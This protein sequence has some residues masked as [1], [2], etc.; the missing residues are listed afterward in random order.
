LNKKLL[1]VLI[2]C[3]P[4]P[5]AAAEEAALPSTGTLTCEYLEFLPEKDA[6]AARGEV[7]LKSSGSLLIADEAH[8]YMG[9]RRAEARGR[10][11]PSHGKADYYWE[12]STGTLSSGYVLDPPWRIWGRS[13]RREPERYEIRRAAL[14]NCDLDPPHFHFRGRKGRYRPG[15]RATVYGG[16]LA[17]GED[18]V[19]YTPVYTRSLKKRRWSLRVDPGQNG[20]QGVFARSVFGY[21]ISD[22]TYGRLYWDHYEKTGNGVG[23]EYSYFHPL[24]KGSL[25]S[26]RIE[27]RVAQTER[28]NFKAGHWQQ[29]RPRWS[30]QA[31]A[32]FQSDS[33]FS[34]L[35]FRD[36]FE[37]VRQKAESDLAV[38]YQDPL[39]SARVSV[40][41][42]EI[43]SPA[44]NKFVRQK[45]TLPHLSLQSSA[46]KL[47][48]SDLYASLGGNFRNEYVRPQA[49]PSAADPIVPERDLYRQTADV[50]G[51]L[52]KMVK[53]T[54]KIT[55][56]PSVG[57]S[58]S[59]QAWREAP[60]G[61]IDRDDLYQGRIFTRTNMRHRLLRS[62]DYDVNYVYRVRWSPNQFKRDHAAA[63]EGLE[64]HGA[65]LF[66]SYRPARRFWARLSSGYD[67]RDPEGQTVRSVRQKI[68]P[69]TAE[70]N[71][72]PRKDVSL[73]YRHGVALFPVRRTSLSQFSVQLGPATRTHF[74]SGY[75]YNGGLPHAVQISHGAAFPVTK[76]WWL[77][78]G[79]QYNAK[80]P[81][82]TSYDSVQF[83]EKYL[84]IKRDLHCW[85][86][87]VEMRER[88]G[89]EEIFFRIDLKTNID[90]R[91][92]LASEDEE[93]FYPARERE[94]Y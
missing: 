54:K 38:T 45:T 60:G 19:L 89:V 27:D 80:G 35:Y 68:T 53:L 14:T 28:W 82:R 6:L 11:Y 39:Y 41:E 36:D 78:G 52:S 79:V 40:E 62:L 46:L 29:L 69:P 71:L 64:E 70:F 90:A 32:I 49:N 81:R 48:G 42:D 47:G 5:L 3:A 83:I 4:W 26:Y 1:A 87:R 22:H 94:T 37:R 92:D 9:A 33:D 15:K 91:A 57:V 30:L 43:F 58:E 51:D 66:V 88:P 2:F 10:V 86:L 17:L 25:Y 18:L 24:V 59:W 84:V 23:G 63:D 16:G 93:Q 72:T 77:D 7:V 20:H 67:L 31:N 55:L 76:G 56:K 65:G 75:S 21:P 74:K 85:K 12:A 44:R 13:I 73:F 34:N 8:I 50:S 61:G